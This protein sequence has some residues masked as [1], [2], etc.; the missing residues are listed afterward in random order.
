MKCMM[1]FQP[2]AR[3]AIAIV[4]CTL[5]SCTGYRPSRLCQE[6]VSGDLER[7]MELIEAG[8]DVNA[9]DGCA[10]TAAASRGE[11]QIV[12][13]LL[14]HGANP[15]RTVSGDVAV[16]MGGST[17]LASAIQ[18]GDIRMV[19]MLLD[20]GAS[21][22]DD[23]E[24]FKIVINFSDIEMA[25]LLLSHG[26]NPN[27]TYGADGPAYAIVYTTDGNRTVGRQVEVPQK[28]LAPGRIDDTARRWQCDIG[29]ASSLLHEAVGPGGVGN[30][31]DRNQIVRLLLERGADPNAVTPR[32]GTTPLMR[33]A[34]LQNHEA[35]VM[36]MDAGADVQA[37]DRCAR[38]AMDYADL[39][40]ARA[41][42]APRT[43]TL[44]D[45]LQ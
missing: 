16:I 3:N 37:V 8:A 10:L 5:A 26:A 41:A 24:A 39:Y 21:P 40:P 20:R 36:L 12:E 25:S 35:V 15:N 27:N 29:D 44:L 33:A 42:L 30:E 7:A 28:D 11:L 19:R 38:T 34:S 9:S 23:F 31:E 6:L 4:V 43:K 18:S 17:P 2:I 1:R 22:V 32:N 45:R 14:D 13:L